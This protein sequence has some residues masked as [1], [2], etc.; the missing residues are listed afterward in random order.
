MSVQ[1]GANLGLLVSANDGDSYGTDFRRFLRAIDALLLPAVISLTTSAPPANPLEGD[2]Y[3]V[4]PGATGAWAGHA[5]AI[6]SWTLKDPAN[7]AGDWEFFSPNEGFQVATLAAGS[8]T[9]ALVQ[10]D[11]GDSQWANCSAVFGSPNT[12]GNGLLAIAT[13]FDWND[14]GT[15]ALSDTQGNAWTEIA[16]TPYVTD[17]RYGDKCKVGLFYCPNCKAGA[18]TVT[19]AAGGFHVLA[20]VAMEYSGLGAF[21]AESVASVGSATS[22]ASGV[23]ATTDASDFLFSVGCLWATTEGMT[24]SP[25]FTARWND[26]SMIEAWDELVAP[27]NHQNTVTIDGAAETMHVVL[28]AFKQSNSSRSLRWYAFDGATWALQAS[29]GGSAIDLQVNGAE[30]GSQTKLDLKAGT[31]VTITDDGIGGITITASGSGGG[32]SINLQ[33]NGTENGSQSVLNLKAGANL[34]IADD[35]SGGITFA[36]SQPTLPT[37]KTNGTANG[38]QSLLNL[39]NGS[40]VTISDDGAGGITIASSGGGGGTTIDLQHDGAENGSQTKLNLK[41]GANVSITDDGAGG[42][43]LAAAQPAPLTL[44][45]DGTANGSQ[46]K[47]NLKSGSNVSIADDGFGGLTIATSDPHLPVLQHNGTANG[48]QDFST[49]R[50]GRISRSRT[51]ERAGSRSAGLPAPFGQRARSSESL[52]RDRPFSSSGFLTERRSRTRSRGRSSRSERIRRRRRSTKSSGTAPLWRR[53]RSRLRERSRSRGA[54]DR[55]LSRRVIGSRSRLPRLRTRR[56]RTSS[57]CCNSRSYKG[58]KCRNPI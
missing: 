21:I 56:S 3:I 14:A 39:K 37:F 53:S 9:P 44:Q 34:T 7:P 48:S 26:A 32:T 5:N 15:V 28:A 42:L 1:H 58:R 4:P 20:L 46:S 55:R 24:P 18:N 50:T 22:L 40:N 43:T 29:G 38:L 8:G 11:R 30:N 36:A 41:S 35:G 10:A 47:L 19:I 12:S 25:G 33:H 49:S 27:G 31:N 51:M 57:S 17:S 54:A 6:A 13:V 2:R 16:E 45:H 52:K 23:V